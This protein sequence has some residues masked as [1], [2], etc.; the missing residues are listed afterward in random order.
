MKAVRER[1]LPLARHMLER[2]GVLCERVEPLS[3]GKKGLVYLVFDG[4]DRMVLRLYRNPVKYVRIKRVMKAVSS[5]G[6]GISPRV[7]DSG[8]L[9][10]LKGFWGFL[11]EEFAS[12]I[13]AFEP[14]AV[15]DFFFRLSLFHR[16]TAK[17]SR[18]ASGFW[19][20]AFEDTKSRWFF[21]KRCR[22]SSFLLEKRL[23]SLLS[24]SLPDW[25]VFSLCHTDIAPSNA[26]LIDG[27]IVLF[28]WDRAE[29]LP[30]HFDLIQAIFSFHALE[31]E[32]VLL[33]VYLRRF[34]QGERCEFERAYLFS[35]VF[36]LVK[37][38]KRALKRDDED[39]FCRY[40]AHLENLV[41]D[42]S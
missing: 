7:V 9:F 33:D 40:F 41:N 16:N 17:A 26:G 27:R 13:E 35:K 19:Q 39:A 6:T 30:P 31:R 8:F 28:D 29:R 15:E 32:S 37:R 22:P 21:I 2:K 5:S 24:E 38:M 14:S 42:N 34:S 25:R 36:F 20:K 12:P 11:L 10:N 18:K 1:F 23:F 4:D 3:G